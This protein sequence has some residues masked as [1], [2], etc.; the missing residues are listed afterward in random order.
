MM[1]DRMMDKKNRHGYKDIKEKAQNL[2]KNEPGTLKNRG[3]R[4][5]MLN[6]GSHSFWLNM[7]SCRRALC[8]FDTRHG[9]TSFFGDINPL[10]LPSSS[11]GVN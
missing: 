8:S 2:E 7:S 11:E 6:N 4:K 1:L 10:P 3:G 5:E 9:L